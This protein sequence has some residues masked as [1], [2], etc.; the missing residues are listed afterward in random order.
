[1]IVVTH[2]DDLNWLCQTGVAVQNKIVIARLALHTGCQLASFSAREKMVAEQTAVLF[3]T[4]DLFE[5]CVP[6]VPNFVLGAM[7]NC[8]CAWP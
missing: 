4:A 3:E 7:S 5:V 1:M 2:I 8:R 6:S